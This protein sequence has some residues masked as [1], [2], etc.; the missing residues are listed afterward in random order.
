[1]TQTCDFLSFS[2][3]INFIS[4]LTNTIVH[5]IWVELE[6]TRLERQRAYPPYHSAG[7][8]RSAR[9]S[10][11]NASHTPRLLSRTLQDGAA[12]L[13]SFGGACASR[14]MTRDSRLILLSRRD[15]GVKIAG[16]TSLDILR[17]CRKV[18]DALK[19]TQGVPALNRANKGSGLPDCIDW[20]EKW[21]RSRSQKGTLELGVS[22]DR[23]LLGLSGRGE[24]CMNSLLVLRLF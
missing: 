19:L 21:P 22:N 8:G 5:E 9:P 17:L 13:C 7:S 4:C 18:W 24:A 6:T 23:G 12:Q 10:A 20:R 16:E 14:L 1:M 15:F 2:L 11:T 3:H